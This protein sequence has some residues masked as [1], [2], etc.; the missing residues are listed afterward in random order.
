LAG[1][2]VTH[3]TGDIKLTVTSPGLSDY[4]INIKTISK[5]KW[6]QGANQK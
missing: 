6:A 1:A 3:G 5:A 4:A 2:G